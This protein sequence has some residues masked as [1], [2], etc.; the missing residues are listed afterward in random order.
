MLQKCTATLL[1]YSTGMRKDIRHL[2]AAC[3]IGSITEMDEIGG[4]C[5]IGYGEPRKSVYSV[6]K[7][8]WMH[9]HGGTD[10]DSHGIPREF[11]EARHGLVGKGR[12]RHKDEVLLRQKKLSR[13]RRIVPPLGL[14]LK[15]R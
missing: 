7:K 13:L 11:Q 1:C 2:A 12:S 8:T 5:G 10:E 6:V 15:D 3:N 4:K 14:H 9:R